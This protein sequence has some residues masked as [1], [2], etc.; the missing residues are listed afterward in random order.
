MTRAFVAAALLLISACQRP[1][2]AQTE[3][4]K[5]IA[6]T[7]IPTPTELYPSYPIAAAFGP[8]AVPLTREQ[9]AWLLRV[10]RSRTYGWQRAD[11]R[12]ADMPG[13]KVPLVIY[14]SG[15]EIPDHGGHV[16]GDACNVEFDPQQHG[17][18]G[19]SESACE[20]TTPEPVVP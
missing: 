6:A 1:I 8:H 13:I 4:M 17:L 3:Y 18:F 11:L 9:R 10:L 20:G 5:G 7:P 2:S 14:A 15:G 19:A 12:F 16:I